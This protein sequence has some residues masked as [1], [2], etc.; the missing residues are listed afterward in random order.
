[1]KKLYLINLFL[2]LVIVNLY[3]QS[4]TSFELRYFS[5]AMEANGETDFKGETSV[6]TTEERVDF[7]RNYAN[8][9]AE[10]FNDKNF[11]TEVVNDNEIKQALENIKPL[12]TPD[13]R[14][15]IPLSDWKYTSSRLNQNKDKKKHLTKWSDKPNVKISGGNLSL[16][17]NGKLDFDFAPQAWRFNLSWKA[18]PINNKEEVSFQLSDRELIIASNVGFGNDG[19]IFYTTAGERVES[20]ISYQPDEWYHFTIEMDLSGGDSQLSHS[21]QVGRYNLYVNGELIAD[22]VPIERAVLSPDLFNSIGQ[23]NKFTIKS[24]QDIILDDI[25]GYGYAFT[26]RLNFPYLPTV[27]LNE[28]FNILPDITGWS[29]ETYDDSL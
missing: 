22:F 27:L 21:K 10:W 13:V 2:G 15:S 14:N 9:A 3:A 18:K 20:S 5:S 26:N 25:N 23:V 17:A 16:N 7:L 8:V 11:Q 19:K 24:V 12:P 4:S 1:M 6:F 29:S 28:D